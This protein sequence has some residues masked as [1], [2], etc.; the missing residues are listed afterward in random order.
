MTLEATATPYSTDFSGQAG[1][2]KERFEK[3]KG[4]NKYNWSVSIS[5]GIFHG[6]FAVELEIKGFMNHNFDLKPR[7]KLRP[8]P[9]F[10]HF[11]FT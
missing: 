4:T 2:F 3:Y 8:S 7:V 5:L 10:T 6:K 11:S 1:Q 9:M